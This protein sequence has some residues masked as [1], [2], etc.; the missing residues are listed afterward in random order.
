MDNA[1]RLCD[2]VCIIA[3]NEKVLDG[4]IS[5]VRDAHGGRF[6]ALAFDGAPS[7]ATE[8][9]LGDPAWVLRRDD[10]N[11]YLELEL[12]EHVAPSALLTALVHRARA[13][14]GSSMY[15]LHCT[16]SSWRRSGRPTSK[17]G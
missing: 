17:R 2:A 4:T 13:S 3:A 10:S 16:G 15:V 7:P 8:A 5:E 9:I 6:V 11:R 12:P 14:N 1:E